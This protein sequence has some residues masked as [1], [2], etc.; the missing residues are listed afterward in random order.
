MPNR[1]I[2]VSLM[3]VN[4]QKKSHGENLYMAVDLDTKLCVSSDKCVQ[5]YVNSTEANFMTC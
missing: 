1:K 2:F 4:T 5:I 3:Q